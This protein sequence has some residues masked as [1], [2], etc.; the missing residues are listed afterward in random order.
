MPMS[1]TLIKLIESPEEKRNSVWEKQFLDAVAHAKVK[2]IFPDPKPGPDSM[3]YLMV[4]T[5]NESPEGPHDDIKNIIH[6]LSTR[7][8]GLVVNAHKRLPDYIFTY[9]MLWHFREKSL[10]LQNSNDKIKESFQIDPNQ[11]FYSGELSSELIPDYARKILKEFFR[12]QGILRPRVLMLSQD[13]INWDICFAAESFGNPDP[14]EFSSIAE[15]ISWFFP[16]HYSIVVCSEKSLPK[17]K[18]L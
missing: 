8:I 9:G 15:A 7:G 12:D 6:W 13:K 3:P 10:F 16:S 18:D 5:H 4:S 11:E 17:F 2:V 14:S 1:E